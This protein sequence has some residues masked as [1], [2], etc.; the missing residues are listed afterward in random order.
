MKLVFKTPAKINLSLYIL[1]KRP[2]GYHELETLLQM[3]SLYDRVELEPLSSTVEL[4]CN[5]P[6]VPADSSNLAVRA[7]HLLK[8]RFPD[9][10]ELGCRIK[11]EKN[12]PA[13][14]GLGG[15]SGNAA[16]VLW[17]LN[18]LWD[19][20]LTREN[21]MDLAADLGS[22]V[23]FFLCSPLALGTGRGEKVTPVQPIKKLSV[24]L[25]FPG[26]PIATSEVYGSPNLKLTTREKNISIVKKF[27]TQWGF[28]DWGSHL[29]NDLEP[30][31]LEGYPVIQKIKNELGALRADGTLLSGSGSTVFAVFE[32]SKTASQAC[33]VCKKGDW[34]TFLTETISSFSEFLP[35]SMIDYPYT[36]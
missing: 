33:S 36:A 12:I 25:V 32:D 27:P 1:G 8:K 3:V 34:D 5:Q 23:P 20:K 9:R 16:G 14:A 21:L 2:D 35:E 4:I 18:V 17:G 31:V 30:V 19:L 6:G 15:G 13:G 11:L 22:D 29:H 26:F 7:A 28:A 24:V 10:K